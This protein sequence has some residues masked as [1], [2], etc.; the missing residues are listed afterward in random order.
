MNESRVSEWWTSG[1]KLETIECCNHLL[2]I[3][4]LWW[5]YLLVPCNPSVAVSLSRASLQL[6]ES[7]FPM[8]FSSRL[9]NGNETVKRSPFV[10]WFSL[11]LSSSSTCTS[12]SWLFHDDFFLCH[13]LTTPFRVQIF[14]MQMWFALS[15]NEELQEVLKRWEKCEVN[16]KMLS[17]AKLSIGKQVGTKRSE[18][19]R[20]WKPH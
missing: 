11:H 17:R 4:G 18:H 19:Q 1:W 9:E 14:L 16:G 2:L 13:I 5:L 20:P 10:T 8:T 15:V 7:R 3:R 12:W 6:P